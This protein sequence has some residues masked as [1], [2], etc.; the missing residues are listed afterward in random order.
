MRSA[1]VNT[2]KNRI[3]LAFLDTSK[4]AKYTAWK[5]ELLKPSFPLA[6]PREEVRAELT[7]FTRSVDREDELQS[8]HPLQILHGH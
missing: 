4:F 6:T 8:Q 7:F 3:K 5:N 1:S 2:Q